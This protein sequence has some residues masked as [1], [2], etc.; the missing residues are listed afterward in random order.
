MNNE[1]RHDLILGAFDKYSHDVYVAYDELTDELIVRVIDPSK[2]AYVQ[3]F[4]EDNGRALL[5]ELESNEII[6]YELFNFQ[7]DHLA[8]PVWTDVRKAWDSIKAYYLHNGYRK[9]HYVPDKKQKKEEF[10]MQNFHADL[11]K[12]LA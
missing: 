12:I 1:I 6:G 3:E 5:V 7:R 11:Q 8:L 2:P 4:E 9:L 10:P